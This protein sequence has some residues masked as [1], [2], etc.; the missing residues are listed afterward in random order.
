LDIVESGV[1]PH[2]PKTYYNHSFCPIVSVEESPSTIPALIGPYLRK[3][4]RVE[5]FLKEIVSP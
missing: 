1:T 3:D 4:V 5:R 2:T